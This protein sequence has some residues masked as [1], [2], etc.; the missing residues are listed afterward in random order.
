[1]GTEESVSTE[2]LSAWG[3]AVGVS[4]DLLSSEALSRILEHWRLVEEAGR[5]MNLTALKGR[6]GFVRLVVDSLTAAR[7]YRGEGP[8]VDIGTGA[9]Y[10]GLVLAALYPTASWVLV[11]SVG[12]K[13]RFAA[14]ASHALGLAHVRVHQARAEALGPDTRE[15]FQFAVA[16]A[17]GALGVV[18]E[19]AVPLLAVGGTALLMRGPA[20]DSELEAANPLIRR[21]GAEVARVDRLELPQG[22]GARILVVLAKAEPS[23]PEF[24]RRGSH[25]GQLSL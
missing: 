7:A 13:A 5:V 11:D 8:A 1:M 15:A 10:P 6:A 4:P 17:A 23:G 3:Q 22:E 12:K 20:G 21:L 16:R 14:Q 19:L 9:G 24:P 25:L 2:E 18:A